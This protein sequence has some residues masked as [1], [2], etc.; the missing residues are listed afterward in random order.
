MTTVSAN[1][2]ERNKTVKTE[3]VLK[4]PGSDG[5]LLQAREINIRM[6]RGASLIS[7]IS[8]HIEPGELIAL[9]GPNRSGKST[10]LQ[11]LAGC[12]KPASGEILVD[13]VNLYSHLKAFRLSI[14]FVPTDYALQQNLTVSEI[15][16]DEARVRMPRR[17]SQNER[18]QRVQSLL[19]AASL[20]QVAD[21]RVGL[22][23]NVEKRK[24]SIVLEV[25]GY[26]KILLVDESSEPL[27]SLE[28]S[29]ITMLLRELSRYQGLT[30]IQASEY[31]KS[32]GLSDKIILLGSG[33][34][35][36]WFGP[37]DEAYAYFKGFSPDNSRMDFELDDAL[38]MLVNHQPGD[39]TEWAKRFTSHPAYQKYVDDPLNDRYT[40][41]LLQ[42][43]PVLRLRSISKE[44]LPPANIPRASGFQKLMLLV[45]RN[46]RLLWRDKTG[47]FM[48]LAPPVIALFDFVLSSTTMSDP[49]LGDPD[50]PPIVLGL[51]VFLV[52][53]TAALVVQNEI[54]KERAVYQQEQRTSSLSFPYVLSKIWLVGILAIYQGLVWTIVH[55]F[56]S[57]GAGGLS[58][59]DGLQRLLAYGITFSLVAFIGGVLG[60]MASAL[61]KTPAM[62]TSWVLLFTI[63]QLFLSG[64]IIPLAH[65]DAPFR[66][67]STLNPSR[68][69]FETLL[70]T[71]GYGQAVVSDPCWRLPEDQRNVLSDENKLSCTCMGVNIFSKCNF[72]G[73]QAFYSFVVEQPEP[74]Q[75]NYE[76]SIIGMRQY[77][78]DLANWQRGRSTVIGNAEEEIAKALDH[79]GQGF[80]VNRFVYWSILTGMSLCLMIVLI[81]IQQR[82]VRVR[83]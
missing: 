64:S 14:G 52:L 74:D 13:G 61:S 22:L 12:Q 7:D 67:L 41:L 71:S 25:M 59:A 18:K 53:I 23:S 80:D 11:S 28:E 3:S 16:Q 56:A 48:L 9:T 30:I 70:T 69:A 39:G 63:P 81:G 75:A 76:A 43:Q 4:A 26:P 27:T 49:K 68:Y 2:T 82:M 51:L 55:F 38:E 20:L 77:A 40:D 46:A 83:I 44:K 8:F 60:L 36:A 54:F 15:L 62:I 42:T 34:M 19:E 78:D 35:L 24:L 21:Q 58:I 37:A 32:V 73:I 47:L 45:G 65:L 31:S 6:H 10:L 1:V 72:P 79:Y 50:R 66:F 57:M 17:A 33:G 5:A 29:Q